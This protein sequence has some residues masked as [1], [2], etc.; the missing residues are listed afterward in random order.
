[1]KTSALWPL[2]H[3]KMGPC[4]R[5]SNRIQQLTGVMR[6]NGIRCCT[7]ILVL[8][9]SCTLLPEDLRQFIRGSDSGITRRTAAVSN[10][11]SE[12]VLETD[13][14]FFL[15]NSND[16]EIGYLNPGEFSFSGNGTYSI[17]QFNDVQL[18]PPA[19]SKLVVLLDQSG[20]YEATDMENF[21]CKALDKFFH[22]V[23]PPSDFLFG[24]FAKDGLLSA[25]VEFYAN[26]FSTDAETQVPYLFN[27]AKR[28]SGKSVLLD[29]LDQS[30]DKLATGNG[31]RNIIALVHG[32]D[33]ASVIS[34]DMVILKALSNRVKINIVM[35]GKGED[36]IEL[37]KMSAETGGL[38]F[39]C[40][41]PYEMITTFNHLYTMLN[42]VTHAYR[43]KVKFIPAAGSLAPGMESVHTLN[44][45]DTLYDYDFS[46]M[47]VYVKIP[48]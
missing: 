10:T 41:S 6:W 7:I 42:G 27:L 28:T 2:K 21:R 11:A 1:M 20:S 23:T 26:N 14:S 45:H 30:I 8:A 9:V 38:F 36:S 16:L 43:I 5:S 12:L 18:N 19:Q 25:P 37:A 44:V 32:P 15:G 46:P 33:N 48:N 39:L 35:L 24:A 29:A 31:N 17:L 13:L 3:K 4:A 47:L 34:S 40:P 22:D